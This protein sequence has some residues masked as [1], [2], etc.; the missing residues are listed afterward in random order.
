MTGRGIKAHNAL[1]GTELSETVMAGRGFSSWDHGLAPYRALSP[2]Q[3]L[4]ALQ[5]WSPVVR[6]RAA[7][8]LAEHENLSLEVLID[9]LDAVEYEPRYGACQAITALGKR[10]LLAA[11]PLRELLWSEDL[12]LRVQAAQALAAIG[13]PVPEVV[14]D[15]VKMIARKD[16]A[17]LRDMTQRYLAFCLF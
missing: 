1:K 6:E 2:R 13:A 5:S 12:W 4:R 17:D 9:R 15:F 16:Q 14:P 10:G 11:N 3:L 8:I 7:K